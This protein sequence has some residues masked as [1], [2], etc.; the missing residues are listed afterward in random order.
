MRERAGR[1][2]CQ[3]RARRKFRRPAHPKTNRAYRRSRVGLNGTYLYEL[4]AQPGGPEGRPDTTAGSKPIRKNGRPQGVRPRSAWV[5]GCASHLVPSPVRLSTSHREG[6]RQV[7]L[8]RLLVR[9]R[10]RSLFNHARY[11]PDGNLA[12]KTDARSVV[13][14]M[15]YDHQN[16]LTG[17]SYS[18]GT[19]VT[20]RYYLAGGGDFAGTLKSLASTATTTTYTHN[21]LGQTIAS[22]QTTP[23]T[24]GTINAQR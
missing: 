4:E 22:T 20:Y 23:T 12:T 18:G 24:G 7:A 3:R 1:L 16:R 9:H 14:T 15:S 21:S 17:K 10:I 8:A 5:T 2:R 11:D 19:Q 13:T 6:G